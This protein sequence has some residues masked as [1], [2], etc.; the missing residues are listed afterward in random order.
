MMPSG[1]VLTF[2]FSHFSLRFL[3]AVLVSPL[4]PNKA[5]TRWRRPLPR[6][7][8]QRGCRH[9]NIFS[10]RRGTIA[11]PPTATADTFSS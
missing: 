10:S 6:C 11:P 3:V 7:C 4:W 2:T 9:K 8:R 5:K 1:C